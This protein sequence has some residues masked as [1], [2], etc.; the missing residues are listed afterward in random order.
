MQQV[1]HLKQ[2]QKANFLIAFDQKGLQTHQKQ[3]N[4][5]TYITNYIINKTR[6]MHV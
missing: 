3:N 2:K 6:S 1:E 4:T 5:H